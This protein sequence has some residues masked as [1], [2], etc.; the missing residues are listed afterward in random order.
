VR[1]LGSMLRLY[2]KSFSLE[3]NW[4]FRLDITA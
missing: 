2:M 4:R 3:N 1:H